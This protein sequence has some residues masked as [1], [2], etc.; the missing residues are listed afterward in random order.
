MRCFHTWQYQLR[1]QKPKAPTS[2]EVN[3]N[4]FS[5]INGTCSSGTCL[6]KSWPLKAPELMNTIMEGHTKWSTY[7]LKNGGLDL[8]NI[9]E[10]R[11]WWETVIELK[12]GSF[13]WSHSNSSFWKEIRKYPLLVLWLII[14]YQMNK[15]GR[16]MLTHQTSLRARVDFKLIM[17]IS[18]FSGTSHGN[19]PQ[20]WLHHKPNKMPNWHP[21]STVPPWHICRAALSRYG[22]GANFHSTSSSGNTTY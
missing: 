8:E 15:D 17:P 10:I 2:L 5:L 1:S 4:M 7:S 20:L 22:V 3:L 11:L 14:K 12:K 21:I 18:R 19:M 13:C 9:F 6:L 16:E